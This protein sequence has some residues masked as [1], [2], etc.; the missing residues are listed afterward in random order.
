MA[1]EA[2][3]RTIE[4]VL[5]AEAARMTAID[6]RDWPA[7]EMILGDDLSYVHSDT[8]IYEDKEANL[9]TLKASPRSYKRRDL[10]VRPYGDVAVMTGEIDITIDAL[11][12]GTAEQHIF[13]RATQ[14]WIHR[15]GRWQMIVFQATMIAAKNRPADA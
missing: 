5:A 10:K 6:A 14:V 12:D 15:D 7:L 2:G 13:S 11:A 1:D 8:G 4:E 9:V 3:L